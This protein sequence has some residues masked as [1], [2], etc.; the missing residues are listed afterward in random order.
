MT[1]QASLATT[2]T[3]ALGALIAVIATAPSPAL[4]GPID[5]S[6]YVGPVAIKFNS[7][8]SFVD[9]SGN[10][11]TTLAVGDQ[12]F[13]TFNVT[14]ITAEAAYGS[15]KAGQTIWSQSPSNGLSARSTTSWSPV[16][17]RCRRRAF[18]P[19]T[20]ADTF[21]F[22]ICRFPTSPISHRAPTAI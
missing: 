9:S 14:S 2:T 4:A 22:I 13:G 19:A 3:V 21:R 10:L 1:R 5:L 6:G 8:K 17:P 20:P 15:I 12:N 16:L 7:Y 18:K 11:A